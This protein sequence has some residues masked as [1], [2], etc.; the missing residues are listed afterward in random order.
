MKKRLRAALIVFAAFTAL[1]ITWSF[2]SPPGSTNDEEY[3]LANIWCSWG[4]WEGCSFSDPSSPGVTSSEASGPV[5]IPE[6]LRSVNCYQRG[7]QSTECLA[8]KGSTL[9]NSFRQGYGYNPSAYYQVMRTFVGANDR[10]S[11]QLVRLV[12]VALTG[13]L[14]GFAVF[15]SRSSVKRGIIL[16]WGVAAIPWIVIYASSSNPSA[17]VVAGTGTAWA[18]TLSLLDRTNSK[19]YRI[20]AAGGLALAALVV[21]S[22]RFDGVAWLLLAISVAIAL[23]VGRSRFQIPT[24]GTVTW[25][26]LSIAGAVVAFA[27]NWR[28]LG[29]SKLTF[30]EWNRATDQPF[31]L[32]KDLLEVPWWFTSFFGAQPSAWIPSNGEPQSLKDGFVPLAITTNLGDMFFPSLVGILLFLAAS[33]TIFSCVPRYQVRTWLVLVFL[34]VVLLSIVYLFRLRTDFGPTAALQNRYFLPW[35]MV[36]VGAALTVD[37]RTRP[38]LSRGQVFIVGSMI[39]VGGSIAWLAFASRY[40]VNLSGTFTNFGQEP[41][42]WWPWGPS[43]L[44]WFLIASTAT[45]IWAVVTLRYASKPLKELGELSD[46]RG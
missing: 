34:V 28:R 18:F 11:L 45:L 27:W 35:L 15:V 40:A 10:T 43:R 29:F 25:I 30:P 22:A 9:V 2:A 13:L 46:S 41:V 31:P 21:L 8:D 14:L 24:W 33:F 36:F 16:A 7:T 32:L 42:W 38:L 3:H 20:A 39:V 26:V 1:G 44:V 19:G 23:A 37:G 6:F 17:W 12:N 4:E 5:W